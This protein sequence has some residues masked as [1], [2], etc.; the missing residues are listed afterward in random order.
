MSEME[1]KRLT[2]TTQLLNPLTLPLTGDHLIEA[3]AGTGKTF[4]IAFLYVRLVLGHSGVPGGPLGQGLTPAEILVVTFTEAATKELRDRIRLRLTEAAARFDPDL[5]AGAD[6]DPEDPDLLIR[7]RA[8][9]PREQWSGCQRRLL[10]AAES[11]DEAAISTIHGWCHRMLNEHAFDSGSLFRQTLKTDELELLDEVVRDYW[12]TCYYPLQGEAMDEVLALWPY[13][14]RLRQDVRGLLSLTDALPA[15]AGV[16][17]L[18]PADAVEWLINHVFEQRRQQAEAL[19][20]LPWAQW[21]PEVLALLAEL[22]TD[23]G[24]N[25]NSLRA[26]RTAWDALLVWA[27]G[28]ELLP[29]KLGGAGF[30]NQTPNGLADKLSGDEP[31]PAH[32]AFDAIEALLAFS[33]NLP[34]P[35]K[36]LLSHAVHWIAARVQRQQQLR[37]EMGFN[38]LLT[39]LDQALQQPEQGPRLA[40]RI[41]SQFPVALIDE[42]QDT[43]PVQYRTFQAVYRLGENRSDSGILLIGDP[44]QAIYGFRGAD[45][46]TYLKAREAVADRLY[47]LG[48]NFRSAT[49]MVEAVNHLFLRADQQRSQGAFLFRDRGS[50]RLPFFRVQAKGRSETWQVEGQPQPALT[51]WW[52]TGD[53]D[54][55]SVGV[56]DSRTRLAEACASEIVRLLMLAREGRAGFA[57]DQGLTPLKPGD[58]AVLVNRASEATA[59]RAALARRRVRS[60]YLSDRSS[61]LSSAVTGDL[62]HWLRACAEPR[63]L[64]L[65]R[66]ALGTPLLALPFEELD[67]LLRDELALEARIETFLGY[68]AIWQGQGVLPMLRR[69]LMDHQVPELLLQQADGERLLTDILHLAELLQQASQQLDGEQALIHHFTEWLSH[70]GE[71]DE[72]LHMRLESDADLVQVV[73][74][75]KS[76]GLEYPLVFLPYA[77]AFR[78]QDRKA[79]FIKTHDE[80]GNLQVWL[81]PDDDTLARADQERLGEEIRKLYVAL[82]RARYATWVGA[83]AIPKWD[84]SGLGYLL[85]S[86]PD[87]QIH[88]PVEALLSAWAG[89]EG[90]LQAV[91]VPEPTEDLYLPL[92]APEPGQ[93]LRPLRPAREHWWIASYSAIA[94]RSWQPQVDFADEAE[95]PGQETLREEQAVAGASIPVAAEPAGQ[96][97]VQHHQ[98]PSGPGPGTFLHDLLEWCARQGFGRVLAEP[99]PLRA[100]LERRCLLRRWEPWQQTLE[101]WLLGLLRLPLALPGATTTCSLGELEQVKPEL[102]FW[103]ESHQ[104][105]IEHLDRLVCAGLHPGQSRPAAAPAVFNGMLKGYIDLVFEAGGR[106]YLLDYK[107]NLLGPDDSHYTEDAMTR[108]VLENRYDLQLVLYTLALHRLLKVR[109]PDYDYDRHLG[110]AV[111]L[112]LRGFEAPGG[113]IYQ[114]RPSRTLIET[115]DRLFA[116]AEVTA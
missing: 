45:I 98:F 2:E 39:R 33:A 44:K 101:R 73:T 40:E 8:D 115:L 53:P 20:S 112:F 37:A 9:I 14:Q 67:R 95:T 1:A 56:T 61:V 77:T 110:G 55:T 102:E 83:G 59:V 17:G 78:D 86:D 46:Y 15:P 69:F 104:V 63:Q 23:R 62:L 60:V 71:E 28:D 68:Q 19:R 27:A 82:T 58:I 65:L 42:F 24:L 18:A 114:Q 21:Q 87:G 6:S 47:T 107:S 89:Q 22:K 10:L 84:R 35:R 113:G 109:L 92:P 29:E 13:P 99:Q 30:S 7:L 5:N 38:D 105:D 103:F 3:S 12:R 16:A 106:Y 97:V 41:R 90:A 75:H 72:H 25:G 52:H 49:A 76:K 94:Y 51:V 74:V 64:P 26:M 11:M 108:K 80:Q 36:A 50:N 79:P 34:A 57:S 54:K 100:L 32:P 4:T 66:A 96:D 91:P 88:R 70:D 85:G 111:Y 43:D 81:E 116:G 93:A 31:A 48:T